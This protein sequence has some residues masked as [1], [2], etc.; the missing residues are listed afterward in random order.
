MHGI[1]YRASVRTFAPPPSSARSGSLAHSRLESL[2]SAY[3]VLK[4]R[5]K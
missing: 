2:D 3:V 5:T 1:L 4:L